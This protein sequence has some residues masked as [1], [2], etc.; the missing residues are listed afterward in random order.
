MYKKNFVICP[1]CFPKTFYRYGK[2]KA[3]NQKFLCK[4]CTKQFTSKSNS[5]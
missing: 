2:D 4:P 5:R 3:R 1:N